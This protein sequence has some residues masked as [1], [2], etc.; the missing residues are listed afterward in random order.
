MKAENKVLNDQFKQAL[1]GQMATD[2]SL[3]YGFDQ[4]KQFMN[5]MGHSRF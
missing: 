4:P 1:V 5:I 3:V 2:S